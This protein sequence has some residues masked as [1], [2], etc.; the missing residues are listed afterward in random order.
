M[1][2]HQRW[3]PHSG[4]AVTT[5]ISAVSTNPAMP[6]TSAMLSASADG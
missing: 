1:R 4:S 3:L 6:A 5:T 2:T